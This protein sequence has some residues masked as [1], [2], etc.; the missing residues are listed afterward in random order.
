M[1]FDKTKLCL[2]KYNKKLQ[3]NLGLKIED[4]KKL[5]GKYVIKDT[6]GNG[7]EYLQDTKRL[8]FEGKYIDGKKMDL[9]KNLIMVK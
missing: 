4:Y 6:N 2:V 5:S 3:N 7:K 9:E 8:I 1:L